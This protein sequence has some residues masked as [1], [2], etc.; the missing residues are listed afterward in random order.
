MANSV[1]LDETARY[2]PSH[3][4][5]HCL[6]LDLHC[7]QKFLFW[8]ARLNLLSLSFTAQSTLLRSHRAGKLPYS[9]SSWAGLVLKRL[10][11]TYVHTFTG[12]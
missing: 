7:L 1:D 6:H 11:S 12:C 8:F 9:H 3:L 2:E 5:L 4:D 10:T